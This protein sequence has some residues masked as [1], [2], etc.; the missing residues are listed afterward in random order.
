MRLEPVASPAAGR[1]RG[2][3]EPLLAE[4]GRTVERVSV[5]GDTY[6]GAGLVHAAISEFREEHGAAGD[7]VVLVR[8]PHRYDWQE[9]VLDRILATTPDV[10]V[11]DMGFVHRDFSGARGWVR[12][13]GASRV[14][15]MAAAELLAGR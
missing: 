6:N 11:L 4:Q 2:D 3:V 8:S 9:P 13:F 7:V 1:G 15:T 10:V 5:A 14:C 12:T